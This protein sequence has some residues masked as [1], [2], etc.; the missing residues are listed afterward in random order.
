MRRTVV[1]GQV[2]SDGET[3]PGATVYI[4]G[5]NY[6]VVSDSDGNFTIETEGPERVLVIS[7]VGFLTKKVR[8]G[9]QTTVD[10]AL[11]ASI[12]TL[13][14]VVVVGYGDTQRQRDLTAPIVT[15]K[16]DEINN[17]P[18][19]N[20]AQS[21]QG[22]VAGVNVV[23]NGEPGSN[24]VIRVRG[25]GSILGSADPLYVVDG[26]LTRDIS[27]LGPNDVESVTVMKD[28][29]S[30]ALYG[31]RAANGVIIIE[32]KKGENE[33]KHHRI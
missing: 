19:V 25:L 8:V 12:E 5:T 21:L 14:E 24:P 11:E 4:E 23:Q 26:V 27:Y 15:I 3:L 17:K 6:G 16:G 28:A 32:T 20:V 13:G 31:M 18:F 1:R 9:N 22:K 33:T 30:S 10:V 7:Y 29:S 2:T